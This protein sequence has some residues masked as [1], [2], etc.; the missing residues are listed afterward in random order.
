MHFNLPWACACSKGMSASCP[1]PCCILVC[2]WQQLAADGPGLLRRHMSGMCCV[3][4]TARVRTE[5]RG[6]AA[7]RGHPPCPVRARAGAR[8]GSLPGECEAHIRLPALGVKQVNM[9]HAHPS[10]CT[11]SQAGEHEACT[12][13][14]LHW[15]S[16]R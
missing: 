5:P 2:C 12:S 3:T 1:H 8:Q 15:E 4:I 14:C 9:K 7:A 13:V 16:S 6:A 11:G 10:A